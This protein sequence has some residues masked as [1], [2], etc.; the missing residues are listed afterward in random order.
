MFPD[1]TRTRQALLG[2]QGQHWIERCDLRFDL[3]WLAKTRFALAWND[4]TWFD[5]KCAIWFGLRRNVVPPGA[6]T[7]HRVACPAAEREENSPSK[8]NP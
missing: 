5:L 7:L 6:V 8:R 2:D 3:I 4:A 1:D